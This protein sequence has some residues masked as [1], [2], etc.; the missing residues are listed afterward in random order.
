PPSLQVRTR[1][2]PLECILR[3]LL[4]NAI[5]HHGSSTGSIQVT[6]TA[7]ED[8]IDIRVTDDGQGVLGGSEGLGLAIV[9]QLLGTQAAEL[10]LSSP[11]SG[12]G[13]EARFTWPA[14]AVTT[15]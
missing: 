13:T 4:C 7:L 10:M 11:T 8:A 15:A 9:R 2:I 14:N 6:V 12:L 5:R 3:N 1:R